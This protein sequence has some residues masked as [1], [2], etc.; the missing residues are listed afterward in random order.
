MFGWEICHLKLTD[1]TIAPKHQMQNN[2]TE[3]YKKVAY[4]IR[5]NECSTTRL[6]P[7]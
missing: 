2:F 1:N 5:Y 6:L 3:F 7:R 4:H